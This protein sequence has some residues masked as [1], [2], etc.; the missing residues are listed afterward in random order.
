MTTI[1]IVE[2]EAITALDLRINLED[3]GYEI[4]DVVDNGD[5]AVTIAAEKR[6][7]MTIMDIRLKG[8]MSGIEASR[9]IMDLGMPVI[10]LTA[11]T[12]DGTFSEALDISPSYAFIGKPF[13]KNTLKHNI[14][15]AIKRSQIENEKINL[16][17]GFVKED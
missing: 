15:Y 14:E 16:A 6:P 10:Y 12:D 2:D 8:E 7:D 11:N 5:D 17:H 9:K 3:L 4:I 13:N 1:L